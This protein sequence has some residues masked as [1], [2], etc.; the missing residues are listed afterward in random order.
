MRKF[1]FFILLF[2]Q[3]Q[4]LFSLPALT[5]P[6]KILIITDPTVAKLINIKNLVD[7]K[8]LDIPG[9]KIIGLYNTNQKYDFSE[10]SRFVKN[11]KMAYL[12]LKGISMNIPIDSLFCRN[13]CSAVF[14]DL[15]LNSDGI[16]F[17]G[18]E[19]I[20]P[21]LYHEKTSLLTNILPFERLYELSLMYHLIA[22][23]PQPVKAFLEEKP[24][25]FVFGICLGMQVMNVASGGTLFQDIPM[26]IYHYDNAE[27]I[28][29]QPKENRHRNYLTNIQNSEKLIGTNFHTIRIDTACFLSKIYDFKTKPAPLVASSH[30]QSVNEIG[31]NLKI[32]AFSPDG[33]VIEVIEHTIYP[34]VFGFQFHPEYKFIYAASPESKTSIS[35]TAHDELSQNDIDF[36]IALWKYVSKI[37][38]QF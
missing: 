11:N 28:L 29:K 13:G 24:D 10:S 14:N 18:G 31:R 35:T 7:L 1:Y 26:E 20:P 3:T 25:Y 34:N 12:E 32:S 19:D 33:K 16:I 27:D 8:I 22:D 17:T 23:N 6:G 9:L 37:L 38:T 36:N 4:F 2:M 15:F 5:R 30:H 21:F